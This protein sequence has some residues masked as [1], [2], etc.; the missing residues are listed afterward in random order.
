MDIK[1]LREDP[2]DWT[3]M[4]TGTALH[5]TAAAHYAEAKDPRRVPLE[6]DPDEQEYY[7]ACPV[8]TRYGGGPTRQR[9]DDWIV[10]WPGFELRAYLSTRR[11]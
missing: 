7:V 9:P 3:G 4:A 5:K 8:A 2:F 11:V 1:A 6:C 10:H